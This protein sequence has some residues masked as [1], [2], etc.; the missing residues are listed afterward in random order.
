MRYP[1]MIICCYKLT[2]FTHMPMSLYPHPIYK[3]AYIP[4][5]HMSNLIINNLFDTG[6]DLI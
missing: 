3:V 4:N 5:G 6:L 2:H 1:T